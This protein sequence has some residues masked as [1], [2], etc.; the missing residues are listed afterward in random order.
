M[1]LALNIIKSDSEFG[2]CS[3]KNNGV[4]GFAITKLH[5]KAFSDISRRKQKPFLRIWECT[6]VFHFS[7]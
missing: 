6:K 7:G 2:F 4:V 3:V 1:S 5:L